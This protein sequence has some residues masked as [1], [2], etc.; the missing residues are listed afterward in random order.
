MILKSYIVENKIES[1]QPFNS[2]LIYGENDGIKNDIKKKIKFINKNVEFLNFFQHEITKNP[3]LLTEQIN[4][5]SLFSSKKVIF[6]NEI[7]DKNYN[8]VTEII[9]DLKN[10]I[11]IYIFT[12][13]LD[14]K[15]KLRSLF[16]KKSNLAALPCYKD[17]ERSLGYHINSKLRNFKGLSPEITNFII[18]NS[19][20]D[21]GIVNN[22]IEKIKIFF[23]NKIINIEDLEQLLNIKS[24]Q[25][26]NL[27]RDASLLGEKSKVN[28]LLGQ[29]QF[30][31]EDFI[32]YL[33]S[34]SA[35]LHKLIEVIK[36]NEQVKNE[37][38]AINKI[39][40]KIFWK[41]KPIFLKQL[42][43]WNK[44]KLQET[45]FKLSNLEINLKA[46]NQARN[47]LL[48]KNLILYLCQEATVAA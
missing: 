45:L 41:D 31:S 46:G 48:L 36:I 20:N 38:E 33:N 32:Y 16:E 1:L 28:K 43:K 37:V 5:T 27:L 9:E 40:P 44:N 15:S 25:D 12:N 2:V 26:F 24:N 13:S 35:R 29:V 23:N 34:I 18:N 42:K 10:E 7:T 8:L 17:D 47:D 19:G 22:E 14:K 39:T 21:R 4:N 3:G 11:K 6:L 30:E